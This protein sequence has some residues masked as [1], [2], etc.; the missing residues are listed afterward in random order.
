MADMPLTRHPL[1]GVPRWRCHATTLV[2]TLV[3]LTVIVVAGSLIVGIGSAVW[4]LLK[5]WQ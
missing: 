3:V 2:E 4:K 5:S 1:H